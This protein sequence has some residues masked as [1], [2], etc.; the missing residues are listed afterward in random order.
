[1]KIKKVIKLTATITIGGNIEYTK[2]TYS[3]EDLYKVLQKYQEERIKDANIYLSAFVYTGDIVMSKQ[4]EKHY[5]IEFL[6]YP[7]FPLSPEIF[8]KEIIDLTKYLMKV[9]EQNRIV[10]QFHDEIIMF[11]ENEKI[12]PNIKK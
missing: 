11:E 1:M 5:K 9:F 8:K 7:K 10:I 2:K 6:N 12:D 3:Q 4:V